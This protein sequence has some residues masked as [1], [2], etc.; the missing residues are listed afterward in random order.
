MFKNLVVHDNCAIDVRRRRTTTYMIVRCRKTQ[1]RMLASPPRNHSEV[2]CHRTNIVRLSFD[3]RTIYLCFSYSPGNH[4]EVVCHRT[5]IVRL[6]Y[7]VVRFT[8]DFTDIIDVSQTHR[9]Q[10]DH[11]TKMAIS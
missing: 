11:K 6:S 3:C 1:S 7:D 2:V 5:T 9:V 4:S 8:Y 10:C